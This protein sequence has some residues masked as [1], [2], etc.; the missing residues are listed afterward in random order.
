MASYKRISDRANINFD[1][2]AQA[3]KAVKVG[4][5]GV[6]TAAKAFG[7]PRTSQNRYIQKIEDDNIYFAHIENFLVQFTL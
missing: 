7:I 6:S 4:K 1:K 5:V 2:S 3:I